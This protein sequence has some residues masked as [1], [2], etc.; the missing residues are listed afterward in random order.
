MSRKGFSQSAFTLIE[1]L[2]VIAIIAILAS[3]L[4]P[5]LAKGKAQAHRIQCVNN[6]KQLSGAWFLYTTDHN[7]WFVPNGDGLPSTSGT[8]VTGTFRS[9]PRDATNH[10]M[11]ISPRY[12]LFSAYLKELKVYKCPS[13]RVAGTGIGDVE[14][15]R[16]RSYGMNGY[17]NY[18]GTAFRGV[19]EARYT[20]YRKTEHVKNISTSDLM[21][22]VDVNPDSICRP[23]FGVY[24]D[25]DAMCHYPAS[26]HNKSAVISF[27]DGHIESK[28]WLDSRTVTPRRGMD[29][30]G[31]NESMPGSKD[32]K[33]LQARTTRL[34]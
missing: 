3:I 20:T 9:I 14:H 25:R 2:V 32:L 6:V 19:P 30:H 15:P 16:V 29:Y 24:M 26:H 31:H 33:W 8:W 23:V 22:F 13:D 34:K 12:A 28:R 18:Q 4:L 7:D 17:L 5:A 10:Q 21:V 1:L 11:L 27:A